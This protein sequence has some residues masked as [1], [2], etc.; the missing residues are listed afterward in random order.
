LRKAIAEA[1]ISISYATKSDAEALKRALEPEIASSKAGRAFVR[2]KTQNKVITMKFLASDLLALRAI[3]NSFLRL[4]ATWRRISEN[5]R[6]RNEDE[7]R[8]RCI[9]VPEKR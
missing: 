1:E 6:C 3:L 4:A 9:N 5:L 7:R 2:V 8:K